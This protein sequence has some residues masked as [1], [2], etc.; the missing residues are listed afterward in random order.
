MWNG[1][2]LSSNVNSDFAFSLSDL[3]RFVQ[4]VLIVVAGAV[5]LAWYVT[6]HFTISG[7]LIFTSLWVLLVAGV[8][9]AL[10]LRL[11]SNRMLV[12]TIVWLAG[13]A[14][15]ITVAVEGTEQ[16]TV[17]FFY[18]LIPLLAAVLVHWSAGLL[19]EAGVALLIV[20]LARNTW[21]PPLFSPLSLVT[22][23]CGAIMIVVGWVATRSLLVVTQWSLWS[24]KQAQR[25]ME[26][27]R[28]QKVGL[29]QTQQDLVQANQELARLS[30]VLKV[31][32]QVA[33]DARR[34]KEEF[35][36]NVSHELRTPLNMIIGFSEMIVQA[37]QTYGARLPPALLADIAAIQRNSQHLS[38]LVDDVL[39]LSQMEVG[40]M[41]L[42][43]EWVVPDEMIDEAVLAVRALF[44]SKQLYLTR[45]CPRDLPR[46]F[47][48]ST[49]IRQVILNLLSN[50]GRFTER[51]GVHIKVMQQD[52]RLVVSVSDTGPGIAGEDQK[53]IF[54]PF[55]QLDSSIRRKHGGSGLG[56]TISKRFV[57]MHGGKLW[58]ESERGIGTT[59]SFSL[60]IE[61]AQAVAPIDQSDARRW[62]S[63]HQQYQPRTHRSSAPLPAVVPHYVVLEVDDCLSQMMARYMT[64]VEVTSVQ[65]VDDAIHELGRSPARALI[66]NNAALEGVPVTNEQL[67]RLPYGTPAVSVWVP[68][69]DHAARQLGVVRYMVKPVSHAALL[70]AIDE[71]KTYPGMAARPEMGLSVLIVDDQSE[72]LQLFARMLSSAGRRYRVWLAMDGHRALSLLRERKPDVMLLDLVMP[73]MDGLQLL[74]EKS[75]DPAI[76]EIPVIVISSKDPAGD[77]VASD[78]LTVIHS[79]GLPPTELIACIQA[80][81]QVLSPAARSVGP[82]QP[83]TPGV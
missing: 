7:H 43:K 77:P 27:A 13:I 8:T 18:A 39:D 67:S 61:A 79:G 21:M 57:E 10:S 32:N 28:S 58:L 64:G 55:Q 56:L 60:P 38:K 6:T 4:R 81:S 49:R 69:R 9:S 3:L 75:R 71:L 20:W 80:I 68:G 24:L 83:G 78:T 34:L 17:I 41:T 1:L 31:A 14:V 82:V 46:L 37:P 65:A 50:A 11:L 42:S 66:V 29:L 15:A 70:S 16:P 54:E 22:L 53:R 48:D 23:M 51:G 36:A 33:E 47:C 74:Q 5:C 2:R 72:V 45:E 52:D 30:D 63:P 40:R 59:F 12:G 76:C 73:G 62:F 35:V 44:E 25:E 26:D 19:A